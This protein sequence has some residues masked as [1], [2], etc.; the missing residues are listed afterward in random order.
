[1]RNPSSGN[2]PITTRSIWCGPSCR[3]MV[4][5]L[6]RLQQKAPRTRLQASRRASSPPPPAEEGVENLN[7]IFTV[8]RSATKAEIRTA[9]LS[10]VRMHHPDKAQQSDGSL[11][12][13]NESSSALIRQLYTAHAILSDDLTRQ[14]YDRALEAQISQAEASKGRGGQIRS[15]TLDLDSFQAVPR[16]HL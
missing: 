7:S 13:P 10:L 16:A 8:D 6:A 1:M 11:L 3:S 4:S 15:D 2:S 14:A 5:S 9:Y 12:T